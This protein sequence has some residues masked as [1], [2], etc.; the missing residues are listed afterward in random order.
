MW[1]C[2][3]KGQRLVPALWG[4]CVTCSSGLRSGTQDAQSEPGSGVTQPLPGQVFGPAALPPRAE[5]GQEHQ[6]H[7]LQDPLW[8][9]GL[10][11]FA[12]GGRCFLLS[13]P[14]RPHAT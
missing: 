7:L 9:V 5:P 3:P 1:P 11:V 14:C 4:L 10:P 12:D 8:K 2:P 6:P 13:V